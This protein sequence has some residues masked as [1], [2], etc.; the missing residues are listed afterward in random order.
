MANNM[1]IR[2]SNTCKYRYAV[3]VRV[4]MFFAIPSVYLFVNGGQTSEDIDVHQMKYDTGMSY[5][6]VFFSCYLILLVNWI[7][8]FYWWIFGY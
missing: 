4:V 2:T 8:G 1:L 6:A 3:Y 5:R 7:I